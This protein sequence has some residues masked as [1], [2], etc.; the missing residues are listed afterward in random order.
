MKA[1]IDVHKNYDDGI[2]TYAKDIGDPWVRWPPCAKSNPKILSPVELSQAK[3][4]F[5]QLKPIC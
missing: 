3:L 5:A 1:N 4:L 2:N